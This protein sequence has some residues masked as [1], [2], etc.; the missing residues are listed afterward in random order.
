MNLNVII[1]KKKLV[2]DRTNRERAFLS[3]NWNENSLKAL[4]DK[5]ILVCAYRKK[6]IVMPSIIC[7]L[8]NWKNHSIYNS[9][10]QIPQPSGRHDSEQL[11]SSRRLL[12]WHC[13]PIT[14][15]WLNTHPSTGN[16]AL[17]LPPEFIFKWAKLGLWETALHYH[18]SLYKPTTIEWIKFE[19]HLGYTTCIDRNWFLHS[20][21]KTN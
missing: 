6:N 20:D 16:D 14:T 3:R 21:K 1:S 5:N 11:I 15:E 13:L 12:K 17:S 9:I 2:K 4:I 7:M 19:V 10:R 8:L 18:S